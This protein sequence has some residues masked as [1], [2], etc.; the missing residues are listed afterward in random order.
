[1]SSLFLSEHDH[2]HHDHDSKNS[3]MLGKLIAM[4]VL[5]IVSFIFGVIPIKV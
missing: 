3:I 4:G 1:M 2:H 5:V